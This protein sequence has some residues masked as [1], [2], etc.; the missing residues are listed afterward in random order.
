MD[1]VYCKLQPVDSEDEENNDQQTPTSSFVQ[2]TVD[3]TSTSV[4]PMQN[5]ND[6]HSNNIKPEVEGIGNEQ[7]NEQQTP[8]SLIESQSVKRESTLDFQSRAESPTREAIREF[9]KNKIRLLNNE[10]KNLKNKNSRA[11]KR[12]ESMAAIIK[13]LQ[14]KKD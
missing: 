9:Y 3:H 1:I 2:Q 4:S 10:I 14:Q 11:K 8:T 13:E 12:I 5:G 6:N 7:N